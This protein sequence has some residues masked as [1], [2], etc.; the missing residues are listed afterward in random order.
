M[1]D[2]KNENKN[3]S[4]NSNDKNTISPGSE[5]N[6]LGK[7]KSYVKSGSYKIQEKVFFKF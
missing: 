5:I 4:N 1:T 6:L 7:I 3:N 2:V